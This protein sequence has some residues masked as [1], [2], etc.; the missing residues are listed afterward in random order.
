V[1]TVYELDQETLDDFHD[2]LSMHS[3]APFPY[4]LSIFDD[5]I[6]IY[7]G[8][9]RVIATLMRDNF[10]NYREYIFTARLMAYSY[11][12]LD[13]ASYAMSY[14]NM[15]RAGGTSSHGEKYE[16]KSK[17]FYAANNALNHSAIWGGADL[18]EPVRYSSQ[19]FEHETE[20]AYANEPRKPREAVSN[21]VIIQDH[22]IPEL[23]EDAYENG[24][25]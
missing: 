2:S 17:A 24:Y 15:L 12:W 18:Y 8:D 19:G 16:E 5:H 14:V 9:G 23:N 11:C 6:D 1:N 25:A 4:R 20:L 21:V 10:T 22:E 7:S 13:T 3:C